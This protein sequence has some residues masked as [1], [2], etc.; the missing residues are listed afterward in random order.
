[1]AFNRFKLKA[2][3][4]AAPLA[5]ITL[6]SVTPAQAA[7]RTFTGFRAA[8]SSGNWTKQVEPTGSGALSSTQMTIIS[9]DT[10]AGGG[11]RYNYA[12]SNVANAATT[13]YASGATAPLPALPSGKFYKFTGGTATFSWNWAID[14]GTLGVIYPFKVYKSSTPGTILNT[15]NGNNTQLFDPDYYTSSGAGATLTVGAAD[16]DIGY[17]MF[18]TS[19][20]NLFADATANVTSFSFVAN[21]EAVPG[22]LPVAAAAAGFAWSRRLRRRLK[23]A[24]T[25]A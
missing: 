8:F 25:Q 9:T 2:A 22:P 14:D 4:A 20:G 7:T 11:V 10:T 15:F 23:S 18:A 17:E 19:G 3:V 12:L 16:T 6:A 24:G 21:Y 13:T 1:M 5:L